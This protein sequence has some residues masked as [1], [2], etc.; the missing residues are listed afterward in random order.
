MADI[1]GCFVIVVDSLAAAEPEHWV[2]SAQSDTLAA[3]AS[4]SRLDAALVRLPRAA[5]HG[6]LVE[7]TLVFLT[8]EG[9]Q[10]PEPAA[11]YRLSRGTPNAE[12]PVRRGMDQGSPTDTMSLESFERHLLEKAGVAASDA[13]SYARLQA[14]GFVGTQKLATGDFAG[15]EDAFS[16]ALKLARQIDHPPSIVKTLGSRGKAR[17]ELGRIEE[18]IRDLE[19][20][21]RIT[22]QQRLVDDEGPTLGMLAD[23]LARSGRTA[24]AQKFLAARTKLAE[25]AGD[26]IA[27]AFARANEGITYCESGD[28]AAG[29]IAL[30][31]AAAEFKALGLEAE[32]AR[33]LAYLGTAQQAV[34]DAQACME[35][36]F[37]HLKL[38]ASLGDFSTAGST[39]GNMAQILFAAGMRT[40]ARHI[41]R[42]GLDTVRDPAIRQQLSRTLASFGKE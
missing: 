7:R 23:A 33:T 40:E 26:P 13:K 25:A 39:F 20:A 2:V 19:A 28:P 18:A 17:L 10:R 22:R 5:Y 11:I 30:E 35:T 16:D 38:C 27:V 42:Q 14:L 8:V 12:R 41:V 3:V 1:E 24:E 29:R 37:A 21:L 4:L 36:Y 6:E 9:R 32:L 15:A 31:E 34:G